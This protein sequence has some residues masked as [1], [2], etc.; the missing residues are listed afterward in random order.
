M[1]RYFAKALAAHFRA[2]RTLFVLTLLG[3]A[4]GVASV[5]SI[6]IL[7]RN[8][9]GAFEGSVKA[10]SGEADLS[11]LPRG[12]ALRETILPQVLGE[13]GVEAAWPLY[14]IDV[15]LAGREHYYLEVI[16]FDLFQPV[17]VPWERE[18]G[19]IAAVLSEPGWAAVTPQLAGEMH[20][21][22]GDAFDVTSGSRRV[23][24]R[25]GA[26]VDFQK[27]T[28]LASRRL[29]VMDIAQAQSLF[30][31][32]G[33]LRQIDVKLAGGVSPSEAAT[34][35]QA[36][37]GEGVEVVTPEQRRR[38]ASGLLGAFRLNLTA[39][40]FISLFVGGFLIYVSTQASLVRRRGEFGLL[41]SVGATPAQ[42]FGLILGEVAVLGVLG[43]TVGLPLGYA[44]AE[45]N[46][47]TVS[48]TLSNLYMLEEIERLVLPWWMSVVAAAVGAGGVLVGALMPALDMSRRD[49]RSLLAAFSL[50]ER[51]GEAS[52]RL[53]AVGGA[54]LAA[55]AAVAFAVGT[56]WKPAGF[57]VAVALLLAIPLLVPF[58]LGRAAACVPVRAFGLAYGLRA[59]GVRLGTTAF[60]VAALAVAV[61]MLT[62]ITLMIGSFRTTV[63]IW[64]NDTLHA[65]VYVTTESWQRAR[66]QAALDPSVEAGLRSLPGVT[67]VDRLR[68]VVTHS[69]ERRI[70]MGGADLS[71]ASARGRFTLLEGNAATAVHRMTD[72]GAALISEPLARKAGLHVGDRLPIAT[73]A[74]EKT[75]PIAGVFYD[76][77]SD[78]GG[79]IVSLTTLDRHFGS[80]PV[81]NIAL[82]FEP[83]RDIDRAIDE[84]K[85]RFPGAPL[86][87]RSNKR[88]REEVFTIFDQTFAVTR[89]LQGMS[90]LI[91]ACGITLSLL[92]LARER[93][94]ELAL[95]RALGAGRS[96]IFTVFLGKGLGIAIAGLVLGA[97][98][99]TALAMVL[100]FLINRAWFGWTIAVHW[101]WG[102]LAEQTVTIL[103]AAV[104]ASLYPAFRASRTP[105]MELSR[106]DL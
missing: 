56:T 31:G 82:Y 86:Q 68:Q 87:I 66:Q 90:L 34:R 50:H 33:E 6:Q 47:G 100:I 94:S 18:R 35:L 11:V 5:L 104:L 13:P 8:A 14:R 61:S 67:A 101:P 57:V 29:A 46:V 89:L 78:V 71:A 25:V 98:G 91:A 55:A 81:T 16:G 36:R 92:I 59:L 26:L 10:V 97:A 58:V 2:G 15:A 105:A 48:A 83:G 51:I 70:I 40:S 28:P 65:D 77:S 62:G 85:R 102:A 19:D 60:A 1:I 73:P 4:L 30:G 76:Y 72:E 45:A 63:E 20:W 24:L 38:Q 44:L 96:Q 17:R 80:G 69:G 9:L 22:V 99:G 74:G 49:T 52:V 95:Y 42:V 64:I 54:I 7:N 27:L 75:F 106:D 88:L 103:A 43:V 41:R 32:A 79:A 3:V 21:K 84:I 37:L 39:L 93:V 23:R 12:P 53:L